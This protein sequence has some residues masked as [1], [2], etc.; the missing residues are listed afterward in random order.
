MQ[1]SGRFDELVRLLRVYSQQLCAVDYFSAGVADDEPPSAM[2]CASLD[3]VEGATIGLDFR[4]LASIHR[5][6][7]ARLAAARTCEGTTGN[8]TDDAVAA[9]ALLCVAPFNN[10][11]WSV[12]KRAL[13][14][15][16]SR[17]DDAAAALSTELRFCGSVQR[18]H[19]K[20]AEAWAH[21]WWIVQRTAK[22]LLPR[23]L[24]NHDNATAIASILYSELLPSA[25]AARATTARPRNY[26]AWLHRLLTV[27]LIIELLMEAPSSISCDNVVPRAFLRA[28]RMGG[29]IESEADD[30]SPVAVTFSLVEALLSQ[31]RMH[32]QL[33]PSD[34]SC[35]NFRLQ[36]M[37]CASGLGC[38]TSGSPQAHSASASISPLDQSSFP[39]EMTSR[40]RDWALQLLQKEL[41]F[42]MSLMPIPTS[43]ASDDC[44]H[45]ITSTERA[46][47]QVQLGFAHE[48]RSTLQLHALALT[49]AMAAISAHEQRC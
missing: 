6:G 32:V 38:P 37:V 19:P 27:R 10:T 18:A 25:A 44:A 16:L 40:R 30:P 41:S 21:R 8:N 7:L 36:I 35:W 4:C 29:A 3:A 34:Y 28:V 22:N 15:M 2:I 13:L 9:G 24:T 11:A 49:R 5:A 45:H 48:R 47:G 39:T 1:D 20:C 23:K 46:G 14:L 43:P 33:V 31:T 26:A 17:T 42:L 12:R